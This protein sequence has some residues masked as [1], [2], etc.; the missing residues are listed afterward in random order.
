[1]LT[2]VAYST[3][4]GSLS[5][6][7]M[8]IIFHLTLFFT[9][10]D[11]TIATG[12]NF[13][14]ISEIRKSKFQTTYLE[15]QSHFYYWM[16]SS[17]WDTIRVYLMGIFFQDILYDGSILDNKSGTPGM[18]FGIEFFFLL[19]SIGRSPNLVPQ[20]RVKSWTKFFITFFQ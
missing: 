11:Q 18:W 5:L 13:R 10:F 17:F 15:S 2:G 6:R 20:S 12:H 3:I 9:L 1:M 4:L 7:L 8:L 14:K 16:I 19:M